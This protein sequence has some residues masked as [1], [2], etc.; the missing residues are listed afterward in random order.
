TDEIVE[1]LDL[2]AMEDEEMRTNNTKT[3]AKSKAFAESIKS[4]APTSIEREVKTV[5]YAPLKP[6]R[7]KNQVKGRRGTAAV[8]D[9]S[10]VQLTRHTTADM[11]P[12]ISRTRSS[13]LTNLDEADDNNGNDGTVSAGSSPKAS[14]NQTVSHSGKKTTIHYQGHVYAKKE[15]I[16]EEFGKYTDTLYEFQVKKKDKWSRDQKRTLVL[17]ISMQVLRVKDKSGKTHKEHLVSSINSFEDFFN[18]KQP[19]PQLKVLYTFK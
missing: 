10:N 12:T 5:E 4:P 9:D 7:V 15:W 17:D 2:N 13:S 8:K 14:R 1:T 11:R 18:P 16:E 19:T 3:V 6:E